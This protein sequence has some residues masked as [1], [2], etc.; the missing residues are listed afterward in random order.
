[1]NL[2]FAEQLLV[3]NP[4][5]AAIQ[6]F[7]EGPLLRKLGGSVRGGT[8]LEIGCGQGVGMEV[9]FRCFEAAH[10]CGIDLDAAQ[11]EPRASSRMDNSA[12]PTTEF[13]SGH[14]RRRP[15]SN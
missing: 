5:R 3:N 15:C 12:H 11:I 10:V 6:M 8:V 4:V 1:M 14:L 9:I 2:N 7:Y 13:T